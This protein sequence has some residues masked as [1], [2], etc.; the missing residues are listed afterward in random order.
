[1]KLA[2]LT[3]GVLDMAKRVLKDAGLGLKVMVH[4]IAYIG[5]VP[6][7]AELA[8]EARC[9]TLFLALVWDGPYWLGDP[10]D[11]IQFAALPGTAPIG[12]SPEKMQFVAL[13]WDCL[14]WRHPRPDTVRGLCLGQPCWR[15]SRSDAIVALVLYSLCW[16][17]SRPDAVRGP[18]LEFSAAVVIPFGKSDSCL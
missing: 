18:C 13:V 9:A 4:S 3:E 7:V 2:Q 10:P 8:H 14:C 1:M 12:T 6:E 11:Q 15:I 5:F 16:R 17:T